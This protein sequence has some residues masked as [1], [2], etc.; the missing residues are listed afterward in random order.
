MTV[1]A[2]VP[3]SPARSLPAPSQ[4]QARS[5]SLRW[6]AAAPKF[7]S[8]ASPHARSHIVLLLTRQQEESHLMMRSRIPA[9]V[10]AAA[11]GLASI[12]VATSLLE[13]QGGRCYLG[14]H[15]YNKERGIERG[16]Y[17]REECDTLLPDWLEHSAPF[18]NWGVNS[19]WGS[20]QDGNQFRGW[21]PSGWQ[22]QWNSCTPQYPPPSSDHYNAEGGWSQRANPQ[23]SEHYASGW[24]L[25]GSSGL[26]CRYMHDGAVWTSSNNYMKLYELDKNDRDE[27]VATI[28]YG[29]IRVQITCRDT[30]DCQGESEWAS[31]TYVNPSS[32]EVFAKI[33]VRVQSARK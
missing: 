3:T 11:S 16:A 7:A 30:W 15:F 14:A 23:S 33:Q 32:S 4:V 26:S 9:L 28:S 21:K 10:A 18:G 20:R 31:P 13:A 17:I 22:R 5:R 27:R 24:V 19:T 25:R 8:C 2:D 1:C 12:L 29:D 6:T